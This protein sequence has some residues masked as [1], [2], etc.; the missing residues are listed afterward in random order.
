MSSFWLKW[1][2]VLIKPEKANLLPARF[3]DLFEQCLDPNCR[4][5]WSLW[6]GE[7]TAAKH[8]VAEAIQPFVLAE[9][10]ALGSSPWLQS[11]RPRSRPPRDTLS[12]DFLSPLCGSTL[13]L[14]VENMIIK[15]EDY[16]PFRIAEAFEPA[17]AASAISAVLPE[18]LVASAVESRPDSRLEQ[19]PMQRRRTWSSTFTM[20]H[21][22]DQL[23]NFTTHIDDDPKGVTPGA[24]G[25]QDDHPR[26]KVWKFVS[27]WLSFLVCVLLP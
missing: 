25:L 18:P 15:H 21:V 26:P 8:E 4:A 19:Q 2:Y 10:A 1:V 11:S 16:D 14:T 3:L 5:G 20:E 17:A 13:P 12:H 6:D 24:Y 9:A 27:S 7:F 22:L 23:K